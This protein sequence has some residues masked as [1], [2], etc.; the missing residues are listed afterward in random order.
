MAPLLANLRGEFAEFLNNESLV[1]LGAFTPVYLCRF[2]VRLQILL[3]STEVDNTRSFSWAINP[4]NK[5]P[6]GCLFIATHV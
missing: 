5:L 3:L 4:T 6:E 1:R 2:A